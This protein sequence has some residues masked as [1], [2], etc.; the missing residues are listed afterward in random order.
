[1]SNNDNTLSDISLETEE[2]LG[3]PKIDIVGIAMMVLVSLVV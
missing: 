2:L 3:P 1:M